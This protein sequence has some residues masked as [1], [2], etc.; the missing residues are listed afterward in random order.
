M[1]IKQWSKDLLNHPLFKILIV[2]FLLWMVYKTRFV[3][4][5]LFVSYILAVSLLP[6][7]KFLMRRK[8]PEILASLIPYIL[9]IGIFVAISYSIVPTIVSQ[10]RLIAQ[11]FPEYLGQAS[12][13]LGDG[14]IYEYIQNSA[15]PLADSLGGSVIPVTREVV[16][17]ITYMIVGFALS[18][19]ILFSHGKL[20]NWFVKQVEDSSRALLVIEQIEKGLGSWVRGQVG[21]A[22][23]VGFMTWIALLIVGVDFALTLAIIT[24]ILEFVP[25]L[26]P[27]I[28]LVPAVAVG[29]SYSP[30][31]ALIIFLIFGLIQFLENNL[32]VPGV[33]KYSVKLSPLVVIV[34][35]LTGGELFGVMGAILAVPLGTV[36]KII[37]SNFKSSPT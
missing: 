34:L 14:A 13:L 29:F 18:F 3:L 27:I 36:A 7:K 23:I 37:F 22:F 4:V 16:K 33:M 1:D 11:N 17:I 15:R 30:S 21:V 25:Y 31:T 5:T 26:G 2:T 32:I 10:F 8:F 9:L 6:I 28:A 20:K 24:G 12:T 35:I 19:Y